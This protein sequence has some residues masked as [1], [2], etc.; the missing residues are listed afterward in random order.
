M[1]QVHTIEFVQESDKKQLL[2]K[3]LLQTPLKQK[4]TLSLKIRQFGYI[5]CPV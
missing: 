4:T 5:G 2:N 1:K 3:H